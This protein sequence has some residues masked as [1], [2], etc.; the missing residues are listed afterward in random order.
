MVAWLLEI[1][2]GSFGRAA[3]S[4]KQGAIYP[5]VSIFL[6]EMDCCTRHGGIWLFQHLGEGRRVWS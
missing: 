3:S 6:K 4:C 1:K 5:C 2:L